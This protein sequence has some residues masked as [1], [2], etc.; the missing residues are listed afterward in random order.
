MS[1]LENV[2]IFKG[3]KRTYSNLIPQPACL[4]ELLELNIVIS[5]AILKITIMLFTMDM[6]GVSEP[7]WREILIELRYAG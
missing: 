4:L 2:L 6:V 3:L 1:L 5:S 7:W